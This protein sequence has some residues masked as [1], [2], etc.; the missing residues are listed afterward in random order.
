MKKIK[1]LLSTVALGSLF[2]ASFAVFADSSSADLVA[3]A[4]IH[5][6][7]PAADAVD[8]ERRMPLEVLAFA[9][10][11]Q[12]MAI[13]ELEGG[14]GYYTEILSRTVGPAG[15]VIVQNPPSFDSFLGDGPA[16]RI[17]GNRLPNVRNTRTNFDELDVADNSIDMVT[18]I[19]GPHE[20]WFIP[21]ENVTLGD[22][23]ASFAEI[24]RV[25]KPGGLFLA[26]DHIA[27]ASSGPDAWGTLH[28]VREN[29]VTDLAE[30]AGLDVVRISQLHKNENDPL[31]AGVFDPSIQGKTSK[32]IVLFRN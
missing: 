25:L 5:G 17:A 24:V 32:F 6:D 18:W 30:A 16:N 19:L 10:I 3:N 23:E 15:S 26:V 27:P 11:E 1:Q 29:T 2:L 4:L 12:G 13:L 31:D 9:G 20:L 28:R 14:G 22:P 21:G 8:D 7:R